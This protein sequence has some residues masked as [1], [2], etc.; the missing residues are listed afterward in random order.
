MATG[1]TAVKLHGK[2]HLLEGTLLLVV[3]DTPTA[4]WLGGLKEGVAFSNKAC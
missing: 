2:S 4:H 1:G 3:A